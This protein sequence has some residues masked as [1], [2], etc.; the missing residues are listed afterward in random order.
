MWVFSSLLSFSVFCYVIGRLS[1]T[2]FLGT[3]IQKVGI[4]ILQKF[5]FDIRSS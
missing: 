3:P 5:D 1:F 2:I 4:V